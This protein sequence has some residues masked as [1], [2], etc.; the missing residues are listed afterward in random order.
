VR[1]CVVLFRPVGPGLRSTQGLE[2]T[3]ILKSVLTINFQ[4]DDSN[5]T[6]Q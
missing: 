2:V 4:M 6:L 3:V 5:L 1:A